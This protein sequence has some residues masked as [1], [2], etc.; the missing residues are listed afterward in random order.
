MP[1]DKRISTCGG[2]LPCSI[3]D[4]IMRG[5]STGPPG[6]IVNT[7]PHTGHP[8]MDVAFLLPGWVVARR[9]LEASET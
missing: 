9:L 6:K 7:T 5:L 8:P 1:A 3:S 4:T 2:R